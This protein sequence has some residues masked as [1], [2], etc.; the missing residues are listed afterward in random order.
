MEAWDY[1]MG[2][3]MPRAMPDMPMKML[4]LQGNTFANQTV[5]EK[6]RG[7]DG[8]AA[9]NML[10]MNIGS[11][12]GD[13]HY[14]GLDVMATLERWTF[15]EDGYPELLQ[16]GEAH[17]DGTP[18]LDAQHPHSSPI[19]GLTLS[20]TISY[21]PEKDFVKFW[22]SPRG[23]AGDG[24]VA[25][26]HRPTGMAN[27]DAPLGHHIGQDVGHISST[28]LGA[29]LRHHRTTL[30]LST[31]N[32][33]EPEPTEVDLPVVSPNSYAARLTYQMTSHRYVM[34]SAAYVKDPEPHDNHLDHLWRYSISF[35]RDRIFENGW[36]FHSAF[37]WGQIQNYDHTSVL[38][39]F[40]HE[41]LLH[42]NPRSWWTRLEVLQR[43]ADE[44]LIAGD[45]DP[46]QGR[47]MAA[48]TLGYTHRLKTWTDMELGLGGALTK[49]FLPNE[50]QRAYAGNPVSG[51]I[52]L[53]L[54]GRKM[55][56]E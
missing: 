38:N 11:S 13:R 9:P 24:P 23:E 31:F 25:F 15:P 53:Q 44:L 34:L 10:M 32:G 41:L 28:V 37:I 52:F 19:M 22:F 45:S 55:W 1:S 54:S 3:C 36:D 8:F 20:D 6:P 49:N 43:T 17:H 30:E 21:G 16:I 14:I 18:F 27:P 26:M 46:D 56:M 33:T 7:R 39:S 4:M 35:Y 42:K 51:K 47:W 40:T 29:A 12:A 5:A 2:M 48:F 50:F